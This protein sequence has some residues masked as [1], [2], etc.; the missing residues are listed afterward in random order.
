M[1]PNEALKKM[2]ELRAEVNKKYSEL[3]KTITANDWYAL[4]TISQKAVKFADQFEALDAW[5]S[6]GSTK[7]DDW[8]WD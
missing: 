6:E 2:R 7:P 3:P 8:D 5:L 1:D 4:L